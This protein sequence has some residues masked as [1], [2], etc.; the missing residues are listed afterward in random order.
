M[1]WSRVTQAP[2]VWGQVRSQPPTDF[3]GIDFELPAREDYPM[4]FS[5]DRALQFL[6]SMS[7]GTP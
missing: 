3:D 2:Q 4:I 6:S 7:E 5:E 1:A